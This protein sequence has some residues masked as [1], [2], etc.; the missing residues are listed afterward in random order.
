MKID[1]LTLFPEM[2]EGVLDKSIIGRAK[3]S[4]L[5]ELNYINIRDFEDC[6][7]TVSIQV[8]S[9]SGETVFAK[10]RTL[11][12]PSL[13]ETIDIVDPEL[14]YPVGYGEQPLYTVRIA[15]ATSSKCQTIGIRKVT[16][17]QIIDDEGSEYRKISLALQ[18]EPHL[19]NG[20]G[21]AH[22]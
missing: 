6:G 7:D 19:D 16:V 2:F 1:I 18:K 15:T 14:W 17:L 8:T 10:E 3:S 11:I 9:P 4:G 13:H 20:D 12:S 22:G 21:K 5:I